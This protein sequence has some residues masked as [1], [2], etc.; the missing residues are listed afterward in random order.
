MANTAWTDGDEDGDWSN[1]ANWS[2][3]VPVDGDHA[4]VEI[5]SRAI[6]T[7]LA[8]SA[9][10]LA[11]LNVADT[12]TGSIGTEATPLRIDAAIARIGYTAGAQRGQGSGRVY[13]DFGDTTP[14]EAHVYSSR[15]SSES[16]VAAAVRLLANHYESMAFVYGGLVGFA[17]VP[18]EGGEWAEI[19]ISGGQVTIGTR[20]DPAALTLPS[21]LV[22][23]G[24]ATLLN[25]CTLVTRQGGTL[26]ILDGT[27][28]TIEHI[29]GNTN[30][31]T[32][33]G[34]TTLNG[35]GGLVNAT[36]SLVART[37]GTLNLRGKTFKLNYHREIFQISDIVNLMNEA[38]TIGL[39]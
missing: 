22:S 38:A 3:G 12:F 33:D 5:S 27:P 29:G 39:S 16:Q 11:S 1:A 9:I 21:L 28:A 14:V 2:D 25:D 23:G 10:A 19:A 36:G 35:Y 15:S 37:L 4:F 26:T 8:Q 24:Q 7:G 17:D 34:I 32:P 6:A 30:L 18:G 20:E 13:V 31:L